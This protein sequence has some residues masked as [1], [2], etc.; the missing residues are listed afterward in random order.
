MKE[1]DIRTF[2]GKLKSFL[3]FAGS[4]NTYVEYLERLVA[5]RFSK[6][7]KV[8]DKVKLKKTYHVEQQNKD[9]SYS[10]WYPYRKTFKE[11]EKATVKEV[12]DWDTGAV[13]VVSF[14]TVTYTSSAGVD[15]TETGSRHGFYFSPEEFEKDEKE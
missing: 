12:L 6:F 4:S 1:E 9:G 10:G 7:P 8:G 3:E 14:D 11:G 5:D 2:V 13:M 15:K